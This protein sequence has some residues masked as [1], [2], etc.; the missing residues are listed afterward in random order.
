MFKCLLLLLLQTPSP[1]LP[2]TPPPPSLTV[3]LPCP[4]PPRPVTLPSG[5]ALAQLRAQM[6]LEPTAAGCRTLGEVAH[7]EYHIAEAAGWYRREAELRTRYSDPL[8]SE[9]D[10]R[11]T[12]E[13][14]IA[15][16][17]VVVERGGGASGQRLLGDAWAAVADYTRAEHAYREAA[18]TYYWRQYFSEGY[19]AQQLSRGCASEV[20]V[21]REEVAPSLPL[22]GAKFEPPAGCYLGASVLQDPSLTNTDRTRAAKLTQLSGRK[23]ALFFDYFGYNEPFP[24]R[25]AAEVKDLGGALQVAWE[26]NRGLEAVKDDAL[27]NDFARAARAA[28]LPIFLR[29]GSEMNLPHDPRYPWGNRPEDFVA[30]WRTVATVMRREAPNVALVWSITDDRLTNVPECWPGDAYVDWV[31]VDPYAV[32]HHDGDLSRPSVR[33]DF[34]DSVRYV[35]DHYA[36]SKPMMLCEL[37]ATHWCGVE[38]RAVP[39]FAAAKLEEMYYAL[40]LRYPRIKAACWLD[41]NTLDPKVTVPPERRVSNY[42]LTDDPQVLAAYKRAV[43]DPY[44]LSRVMVSGT[45]EAATTY[46]RLRDGARLAGSVKLSSYVHCFADRPTVLWQVDGVD[47][48][49]TA[50]RPFTAQWDTTAVPNGP[51]TLSLVVFAEGQVAARAA[52]RVVV[53][54]PTAPPPVLVAPAP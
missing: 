52:C 15:D 44:Y 48:A 13:Q 20:L 18:L 29:F 5:P 47:Q 34:S 41:L 7:A 50:Q 32:C 16:A 24:A 19:A 17:L 54:N 10:R 39:R 42:G 25:W 3:A 1:P 37:G 12:L 38:K 30:A 21:C 6:A 51:H 46:P 45:Q 33:E 2:P 27:L 49:A 36:H 22:S 14:R 28:N 26:P 43:A 11:A 53:A 40:P 35:Y 9:A 31:G 23:H 4:P 8:A